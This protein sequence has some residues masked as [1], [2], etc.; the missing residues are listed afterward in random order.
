MQ[1]DLQ[2]DANPR[3]HPSLPAPRE[4]VSG[5]LPVPLLPKAATVNPPFPVNPR[6]RVGGL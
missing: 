2:T 4:L 6:N 1:P 3:L 5:L